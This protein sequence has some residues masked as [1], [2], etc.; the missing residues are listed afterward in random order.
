M[1][2]NLYIYERNLKE[3]IIAILLFFIIFSGFLRIYLELDKPVVLIIDILALVL[4]LF[5]IL[6]EY[7]KNNN[8][9]LP[10]VTIFLFFFIAICLVNIF[11]P[12]LPAIFIGVLGF[13]ELAFHTIFFFIGYFYLTKKEELRFVFGV[14][15]ILYLF[16]IL[17]GFKQYIFGFTP[18]ELAWNIGRGITFYWKGG[19]R[20]M[21]FL[22]SNHDFATIVGFFIIFFMVFFLYSG[23]IKKFLFFSLIGIS[24]TM[25][26]LI[27]LRSHWFSLAFTFLFLLL[28]GFRVIRKNI[29][30]ILV[31]NETSS[32][33]AVTV[34]SLLPTTSP[35]PVKFIINKVITDMK[36]ITIKIA[37]IFFL[38]TLKPINNKNKNVKASENQ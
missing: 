29:F 12:N 14:G 24:V 13:R 37:K 7:V 36:M 19:Y 30:A 8:I 4:F 1:K 2:S 27:M 10:K 18:E 28:I 20:I 21:S 11:N 26:I 33:K 16:L 17:Y 35:K 3:I 25:I 6:G 9:F 32:V 34:S 5:F 31:L 22:P 38:I 15:L 23:G